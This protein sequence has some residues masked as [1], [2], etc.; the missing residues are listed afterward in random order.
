[1]HYL[2]KVLTNKFCQITN[3]PRNGQY[4]SINYLVGPQMLHVNYFVGHWSSQPLGECL[5]N[6][7]H[8]KMVKKIT[9]SLMWWERA[10]GIGLARHFLLVLVRIS[11]NLISC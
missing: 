5:L 3:Q 10:A 11:S 1:M 9:L 2:K 7:S 6:S 8:T 4:E